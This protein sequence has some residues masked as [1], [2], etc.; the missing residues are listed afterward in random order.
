MAGT[1]D[2]VKKKVFTDI[3]ETKLAQVSIAM[4]VCRGLFKGTVV[5]GGSVDIL[6][7][8]DITI[9]QYTGTITHQV[10]DGTKQTVAITH[11]PY[12]SIKLGA[13][14][15]SQVPT[16][17]K[18]FLIGEASKKIALDFDTSLIALVS[19]A[20]V[21]VTGA[22]ATVDSAF[23]GL[24]T[25][26]DTANVAQ[27]DR[28]VILKPSVANNLVALLGSKLNVTQSAENAYKGSMG[29]YMGIEIFKSNSIGST[30][31]V[32]NCV[33]VDMSALVLAKSYNEVRTATSDTFFGIALQGLIVYGIDI[34]ET[35]TGASDRIIA[36]DIDEA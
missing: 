33:G 19:K 1:L 22:I 4:T 20:V 35:Q 2:N 11:K 29:E 30:L 3:M 16:N 9:G 31:T 6:G 10:F 14:D 28:G 36:F 23:V 12:Y 8:E 7:V 18:D 17:Q 21:T 25:A 32:A 24:A 26:F 13:D 27:G 5:N 34:V 15:L